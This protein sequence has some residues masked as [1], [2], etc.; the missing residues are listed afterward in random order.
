MSDSLPTPETS[1]YA[2]C[3]K[4]GSNPEKRV[5]RTVMGVTRGTYS[6]SDT[7]VWITEWAAN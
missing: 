4:C 5:E 6:H 3:P 1:V 2:I 7:H